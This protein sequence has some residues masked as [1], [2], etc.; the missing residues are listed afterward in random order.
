MPHRAI[1]LAEET[2]I[3]ARALAAWLDAGQEVAEVWVGGG[4][5]LAKPLRQPLALAFPDWSVRQVIR[6]RRLPVHRCPR[7]RSWT[8]APARAATVRADSL[9]N[10]LGLQIIPADLL[11]HFAGRAVNVHPALLPRYRGPCPRLGMIV[12]GRAD[13]AGGVCLHLLTEGIDEGAI[14]GERAVPFPA[15]GGFAERDA[16]LADAAATLV[17]E[18]AIPHLDGRIEPRPQDESLACYRKSIPGDLDIGPTTSL[19]HAQR[20][21]ARLGP[22][23]RLVC[24]PTPGGSRRASYHV[25]AI[26]RV[27]SGPTGQ[28]AR[29]AWRTIELDL[30]DARVRLR[31]RGLRDRVRVQGEAI[32]ALRRRRRGAAG[33]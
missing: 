19:T 16:R 32:A 14:V 18:A 8:D 30:A 13:E 28:P 1:V 25:T 6:R 29:P 27:L 9:L 2:W 33:A 21:V 15:A 22:L 17:R 12:D 10:L 4:S 20:L 31:R 26:D 23:G 24:K 7:L 3:A 11:A 5:S